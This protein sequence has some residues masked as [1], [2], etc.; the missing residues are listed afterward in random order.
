[1]INKAIKIDYPDE[2]YCQ[3]NE[4]CNYDIIVGN[5]HDDFYDLRCYTI[6]K[7]L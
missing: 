7:T 3:N 5:T 4:F 1:M 2:K 6:N